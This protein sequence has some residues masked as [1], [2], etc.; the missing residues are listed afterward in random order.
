MKH[1]LLAIAILSCSTAGWAGNINYVNSGPAV[2]VGSASNSQLSSTG[3]FNPAAISLNTKTTRI[4]VAEGTLAIDME[5]LGSFSTVFEDMSDQ[6]DEVTDTFDAYD[7]D[8]ATAGDVLAAV[9]DLETTL[10]E[11]L[12]MLSDRFYFTTSAANQHSVTAGI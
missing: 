12:N 10:D 9:D 8:E 5:G 1:S 7:N 11:N 4:G 2:T 6:I 3:K